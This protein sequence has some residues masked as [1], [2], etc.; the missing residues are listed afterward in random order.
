MK[1]VEV[2]GLA[3]MIAVLDAIVRTLLVIVLGNPFAGANLAVLM[4]NPDPA[5]PL[6]MLLSIINVMTFWELGVRSVGLARLAG[7]SSMKAAIW[8]FGIWVVLQSFCVGL[9]AAGYAAMSK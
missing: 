4:K 7:V 6:F 5:T 8:M 1:A 3:G 9:S 2:C